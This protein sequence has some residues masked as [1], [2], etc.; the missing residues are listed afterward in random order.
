MTDKK[1]VSKPKTAEKKVESAKE[2]TASSPSKKSPFTG[3]N[4]LVRRKPYLPVLALVLVLAIGYGIY[5][6]SKWAVVATV[7]GKPISRMEYTQELEKAAGQ[8]VLEG[9]VTKTIIQQQ[10]EKE[11]INVSQDEINGE[12]KKLEDQLKTQGQTLDQVL[13]FQGL[14]RES[15]QEQIRLQKI[16]EKLVGD[17]KVSTEE[18]DAYIEQN[19]DLASEDTDLETLKTQ[20]QEQLKRQK[21]D[22]QIQQLIQNLRQT[23]NVTFNTETAA[24]AAQ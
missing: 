12:I 15:L 17:V 16:V 23:S 4:E 11:G 9:I 21:T 10:A 1:S 14:T 19:E 2:S 7:N 8:Q 20:A 24:P 5:A 13:S 6:L 22:Q 3:I 18:V